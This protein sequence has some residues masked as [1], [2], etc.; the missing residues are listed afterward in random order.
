MKI[1]VFEILQNLFK[2]CCFATV[3]FMISLWIHNYMQ[4]ENLCLVDYRP[5]ENTDDLEFPELSLCLLYDNP[6]IKDKF[7]DLNTTKRKYRKHLKGSNFNENLTKIDYNEVTINLQDY[8][9]RTALIPKNGTHRP[10]YSK[11]GNV[12]IRATANDFTMSKFR[13]CFTIDTTNLNMDNVRFVGH[14]FHMDFFRR[15]VASKKGEIVAMVHHHNQLLLADSFRFLS[16]D[17]NGSKSMTIGILVNK[18]EILRRRNKPKEPCLTDVTH[19][20]LMEV[21]RYT[22][23]VGCSAPY[24]KPLENFETCSTEK[25]MKEWNNFSP[26]QRNNKGNQPCQVMP[27]A[28]F[29]FTTEVG[30]RWPNHF[31]LGVSYPEQV[32]IITQSRAVDVNA[33]IGNIGGYIG[34]FLGTFYY[35]N[36][37]YIILMLYIFI[38]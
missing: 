38:S 28:D 14:I 1:Q 13:K 29:E 3:L 37:L 4:D 20:D 30:I 35:P 25:K 27:R 26:V 9:K 18:V 6:F 7:T 23:E 16:P 10:G 33:L 5:L 31:I 24:Q 2:F 19:W 34:L 36:A 15:Y 22:K 17:S 12:S 21:L 32:K 8:Y 11:Y